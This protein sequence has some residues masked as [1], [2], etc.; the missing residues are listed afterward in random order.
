M[1]FTLYCKALETSQLA[2]RGQILQI[3]EIVHYF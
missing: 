3:V 1:D 2:E